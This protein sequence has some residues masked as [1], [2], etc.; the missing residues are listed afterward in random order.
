MWRIQSDIYEMLVIGKFRKIISN[1]N[2]F[3]SNKMEIRN[4][5]R[6][7]TFPMFPINPFR[8]QRPFL[9][10]PEGWCPEEAGLLALLTKSLLCLL[11]VIVSSHCRFGGFRS[12]RSLCLLLVCIFSLVSLLWFGIFSPF[13]FLYVYLFTSFLC[14]SNLPFIQRAAFRASLSFLLLPPLT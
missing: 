10:R 6:F 5:W 3:L 12:S 13:S 14:V 7:P 2:L 9:A 1:P 4:G 8:N 11:L